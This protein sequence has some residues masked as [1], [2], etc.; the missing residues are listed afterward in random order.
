[1]TKTLITK[2]IEGLQQDPYFEEFKFRKRDYTFIK[3]DKIGYKKIVIDNHDSYDPKRDC[4]AKAIYPMYF[5]RFNILHQWFEKHSFRTLA[6]QRD[7][8]SVYDSEPLHTDL[9]KSYYYFKYD[10]ENFEKDLEKL[11]NDIKVRSQN[12]FNKYKTLQDMYQYEIVPILENTKKLEGV[13]ADWVFEYLKLCKTVAPE[14]YP[15]LK[16][17]LLKQIEFMYGREEPNVVIYYPKLKDILF[18]IENP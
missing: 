16:E 2:I 4:I 14:K 11:A 12:F 9:N 10:G 18:D 6:T 15:I 13:G 17:I 5:R 3:K 8:Y 7:T 1:M